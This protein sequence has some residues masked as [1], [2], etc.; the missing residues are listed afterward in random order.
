MGQALAHSLDPREVSH[1]IADS[2]LALL[3]ARDVVVYRLEPSTGDLVSMAFAGEG[4]A[5]FQHPLVLPPGCGAS[6]RAVLE[7]QSIVTAD[8]LDDPRLVHPPDQRIRIERAGYRA[9]MASPL[10]VDGQPIGALGAAAG[11]GR[12]FDAESRRLLEAFA[13]QAAVAL[14][15]ARLFAAERQARA[16]AQALERRFHDLVNG[17]DAILT[18]VELP[19]RRVLFVNGRVEPMLGYTPRQW[20]TEP[21]FWRRHIHPDDR[22]RAAAFSDQ[23][24]A[25]G[26]EFV[27]EYRM[28]AADGRVVWIRDS[29]T[30]SPGRLHS[31]K[32]D[33]TARKRSEALLAG[34][35]GVLTLIAAGTPLPRVLDA[36]CRVLEEQDGDMVCS[37][38]LVED[39]R[40]RWAAGPR[41]PAI[42]TVSTPAARACLATST[43]PLP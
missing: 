21:D 42:R 41:L 11:R 37:V 31:L 3:E 25:A 5:G 8:L 18:E 38:L 26:R 4:A 14:N 10:L 35:S 39:G 7:R 43:G 23:E 34:E 32:V 36:L 15:N 28:L 19:G 29:V 17:V 1:L 24:L 13:D 6:G 33:I 22:E 20:M 40:L 9:V 27:H 16:D 12:V 2:V 30:S